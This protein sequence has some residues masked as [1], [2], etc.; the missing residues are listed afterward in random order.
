MNWPSEIN[1]HTE[2]YGFSSSFVYAAW[3]RFLLLFNSS[4]NK[5]ETKKKRSKDACLF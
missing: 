4:K 2:K 1:T 5:N 3:S